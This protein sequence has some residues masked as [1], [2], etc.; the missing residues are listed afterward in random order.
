MSALRSVLVFP[1]MSQCFESI[2]QNTYTDLTLRDCSSTLLIS[3]C[4]IG[5]AILT[6]KNFGPRD[7]IATRSCSERTSFQIS[8]SLGFLT[9]CK[10]D[11]QNVEKVRQLRCR[12][13]D[14]STYFSVRL[15]LHAASG[16]AERR[17]LNILP[18]ENFKFP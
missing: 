5:P 4:R 7:R 13:E 9:P 1:A 16:L 14:F 8:D 6:L 17:F 12:C 3:R 2:E 10:Y 11:Q 18:W 15:K